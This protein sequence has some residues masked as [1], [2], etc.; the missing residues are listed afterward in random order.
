M[1]LR[2][3]AD[4]NVVLLCA[5]PTD[6][7]HGQEDDSPLRFEDD[8][9]CVIRAVLALGRSWLRALLLASNLLQGALCCGAESLQG[10]WLEQVV[11][12]VDFEGTQRIAIIG[13]RED[14]ARQGWCPSR[15]EFADDIEAIHIWHANVEEEQI[16]FGGTHQIDRL[17]CGGAFA[18]DL[19]LR[20]L[21]EELAQL[22]PRQDLIICHNGLNHHAPYL[23]GFSVGRMENWRGASQQPERHYFRSRR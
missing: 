15:R 5:D 8:A 7:R 11:D 22:L 1:R 14:D 21:A 10:E 12:S 2:L 20:Y 4:A 6:L 23:A 19:Y 3:S 17:C 16:G 9:R 13:C 18:N